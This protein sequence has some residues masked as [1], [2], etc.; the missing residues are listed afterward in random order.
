MTP[1]KYEEELASDY[2]RDLGEAD[3]S[4]ASIAEL[5]ASYR[6]DIVKRMR[7]YVESGEIYKIDPYFDGAEE[8]LVEY[9]ANFLE[10]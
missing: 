4:R 5:L 8:V 1:T 7:R 2:I 6:V 10:R 3:T 9:L